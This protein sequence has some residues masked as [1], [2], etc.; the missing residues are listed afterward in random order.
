M[1]GG[2]DWHYYLAVKGVLQTLANLIEKEI[3]YFG[4]LEQTRLR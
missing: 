4:F 2:G 3:N 1:V